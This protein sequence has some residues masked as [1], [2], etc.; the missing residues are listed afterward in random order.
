MTYC[1]GGVRPGPMVAR[2]VRR[3]RV[4]RSGELLVT[5]YKD[6]FSQ[7]ARAHAVSPSELR[8]YTQA[9]K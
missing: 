6:N 2:L 9:Y 5:M 4:I 1:Q 8:L 7:A 3:L